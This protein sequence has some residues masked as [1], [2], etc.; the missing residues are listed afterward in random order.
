MVLRKIK[1][2]IFLLGLCCFVGLSYGSF[3]LKPAVITMNVG[4]GE[5]VVFVDIENTG[6]EPIA[7]SLKVLERVLDL[8]GNLDIKG[9]AQCNDFLV[10]PSELIIRPKERAKVQLKYKGTK[11]VTADK[12]FILFSEEVLL[13]VVEDEN[14]NEVKVGVN[15]LMSYYTIINMETGKEGK[16]T[17]V[18]S[19]FIDGGKIEVIVENTSGGRVKV[20]DLA[21]KTSTDVINDFTGTK[22]SI[23]PGQRRRFTFKYLRPL[24]SKEVKFVT[25]INK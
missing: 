18:S 11:K 8:D 12:S 7:V 21:I 5:R 1:I 3:S 22:N 13:P 10:Y 4:G 2:K 14:E 20:G 6:K 19:K 25:K 15:T 23:L 24:T 16:L 9:L 17:F